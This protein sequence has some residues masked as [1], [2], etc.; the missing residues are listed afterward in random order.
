MERFLA[1]EEDFKS[2][3]QSFLNSPAG[4]EAKKKAI[5]A[6]FDWRNDSRFDDWIWKAFNSGYPWTQSDEAERSERYAFW[7]WAQDTNAYEGICYQ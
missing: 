1:K 5:A 7:E 2:W 6:Q 3:H 4:K